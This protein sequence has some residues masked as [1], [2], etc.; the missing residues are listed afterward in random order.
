MSQVK[1][2]WRSLEEF[3]KDPKFLEKAAREFPEGASELKSSISRRNFFKTMGASM[4]LAGL[5][6][7]DLIRKPKQSIYPYVKRPEHHIPGNSLYFATTH[8]N[9]ED[10]HGLLVESHE[11]R[12]TKIEGNPLHPFNK[13]GTFSFD[14]ASVLDLYDPDRIKRV[15]SNGKEVSKEVVNEWIKSLDLNKTKG[16]EVGILLEKQNSPTL[17]RL[18]K[19]LKSKYPEIK[20]YSYSVKNNDNVYKGLK[21]ITKKDVY[22]LI[23]FKKP[24]VIVS[25]D[26]DFVANESGSIKSFKEFSS[27][28]IPEKDNFNRLYQFESNFTMT[29][30]LADHRFRVKRS[31][32]E[33]ICYAILKAIYQKGVARVNKFLVLKLE[34]AL[35]DSNEQLKSIKALK[36]LPIIVDDLINNKEKSLV[37]AGAHLS[38]LVHSLVFYINELLG[39]N[40]RII[41]Y[42]RSFWSL[43]EEETSIFERNNDQSSIEALANDIDSGIISTLLVFNND[44]VY[45]APA[46]LDFKTKISKINSLV[47]STLANETTALA[48][49]VVPSTHYLEEWGDAISFDGYYSVVQPLITPLYQDSESSLSILAKMLEEVKELDVIVKETNDYSIEEWKRILHNGVGE[50]TQDLLIANVSTV[51][52][53]AFTQRIKE[54]IY[55]SNEEVEVTFDV[56]YSVF[57]GRYINNAWMQELPDP[58]TKLTWDNPI[59]FSHQTAK[60]FN[61]KNYD[62]ISIK[63]KEAEIKGSVWILPG[64]ADDSL[65]LK[66]GYGQE[67]TGIIGKSSGFNVYPLRRKE[68]GSWIKGV[69]IK[70]LAETYILASVQDHWKIDDG[71]FEGKP[72]SNSQNGRPL[73]REATLE[74]FKKDPE[75]ARNQVEV[76]SLSSFHDKRKKSKEKEIHPMYAKDMSIFNE[77]VLTGEYQWGMAVDMSSCS[78]CN[79]CVVACQ[80]ENNIPVVG[81][82]MV[83]EGREMHWL[84]LDRYFEGDPNDPKMVHHPVSCLHCE[85][86]PCEQVCPVAATVHSNEGLNDM[87][88]NRCIG[89]RFCANNCPVKVRRFN[90]F[91]YHQ[92]SPHS[93]KKVSSHIFELLKEPKETLQMQFNPN[94]TVRMR[95]VME[96]CTYCVQRINEVRIEAKT[97]R[98]KIQDGEIQT[99]CQQVCPTNSIA[100]GDISDPNSEV[101]KRKRSK[102]DYHLLAEL[103]IKPRTSYLAAVTNPNPLIKTNKVENK[104]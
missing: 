13:G 38:P 37:I 97:E 5:T 81:K 3:Q 29:G 28:R 65:G 68:T 20:L 2:Y 48:K 54:R 67:T 61:V 41:K 42:K 49:V 31:N 100:F 69:E 83:L 47:L 90:F 59:V 104:H 60:R 19:E 25:L 92:E 51:G 32:I 12:P 94:V 39:N 70:K 80:A 74:E 21:E 14:Q 76:P 62:V 71:I 78:G 75:F 79:A 33:L 22:P 99:A 18:L 43:K 15:L 84:R 26:S 24:N 95:G 30:S 86:A 55:R 46:D 52:L 66:F 17:K 11:G 91:D 34:E 1:N 23:D 53:D 89:T 82:E 103:N 45:K 58:I 7:C 4:A 73:Y 96:K 50:R 88:Y 35:M 85:Q 57:D 8:L 77:Q 44:P 72:S 64:Q 9:G 87:V 102:R 98:R 27:R 63:Y 16:K 36:Y 40:Q 56:D 93:Q 10:A 6:G 101:S